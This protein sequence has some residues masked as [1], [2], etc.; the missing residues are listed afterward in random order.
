MNWTR[1]LLGRSQPAV[2]EAN[3]P[4]VSTIAVIALNK[5]AARSDIDMARQYKV[6]DDREPASFSLYAADVGADDG[7]ANFFTVGV[8][9]SGPFDRVIVGSSIYLYDTLWTGDLISLIL[10]MVA[11]D[12]EVLF[13][14]YRVAGALTANGIP[15]T[16]F[17]QLVGTHPDAETGGHLTFQKKSIHAPRFETL[18]SW[19]SKRITSFATSDG[20]ADLLS[21]SLKEIGIRPTDKRYGYGQAKYEV[22]PERDDTISN[23]GPIPHSK[24]SMLEYV[25][26]SGLQSRRGSYDHP[27]QAWPVP[28]VADTR[29]RIGNGDAADPIASGSRSA[30]RKSGCR[31]AADDIFV[32]R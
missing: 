8:C 26:R 23:P 17:R 15:D 28:S 19:Y 30:D 18:A 2:S 9:G 24:F 12:G 32:C 20:R 3:T 4:A 14:H 31:G 11:E 22:I 21:S 10:E 1:R 5:N 13:R 7:P 6:L 29:S 16:R 25:P 27:K